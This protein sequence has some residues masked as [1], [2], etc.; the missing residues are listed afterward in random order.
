MFRIELFALWSRDFLSALNEVFQEAFECDQDHA[1]ELI[2]RIS[3]RN[4]LAVVAN[5]LQQANFW[6]MRFLK[7]GVYAYV[8]QEGRVTVESLKT[9][10]K[11]MFYPDH[12]RWTILKDADSGKTMALIDDRSQVRLTFEEAALTEYVAA[13]MEE[14]GADV[15][16]EGADET[17]SPGA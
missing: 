15:V 6:S 14:R 2:S 4:P 9:D 7:F 16:V 12:S 10:L 3:P 8:R 11:S 5:S 13:E 17:A 1:N